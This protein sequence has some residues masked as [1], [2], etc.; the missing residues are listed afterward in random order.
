MAGFADFLR[1]E[2]LRIILGWQRPQG[3]W[4]S[5]IKELAGK[6]TLNDLDILDALLFFLQHFILLMNYFQSI[7]Y[8][9]NT[10]EIFRNQNQIQIH[11]VSSKGT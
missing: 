1:E 3:C 7:T 8:I 11:Y 5:H 2:W 6:M 9:N 10:E 4:G